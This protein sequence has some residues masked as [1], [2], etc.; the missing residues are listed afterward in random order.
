MAN[1]EESLLDLMAVK[2]PCIQIRTSLEKEVF[3]TLINILSSNNI[4][5]IYRIDELDR[6][7][8][9]SVNTNGII[10]KQEV[11]NEEGDPVVFNPMVLLPWTRELMNSE[12]NIESSAFIFV[13]YDYTFD[14]PTFRRWIKDVFEFSNKKYIPFI[15]ISSNPSI[16]EDLDHLFSVIYYDTPNQ[17][18]IIELLDTYKEVKNVQFDSET[19]ADKF[20]GFNRTE[21]IEC[22]DYSFYKYDEI[23]LSYL[24]TKR[25]EVIKKSNILDYKEP[26]ISME[27]IAGNQEFKR[28]YNEVKLS[29]LPEARQ[30]NIPMPKGYLA[31]GPAGQGKTIGA[32]AIA[33]DLEIP[34]LILNMSSILSKFVGE[35]ER[36]IDTAVKLIKQSAPC[37]LLID[38][39]EKNLGGYASSNASDSGTLARVFGKILNLLA[40][41]DNGIFTVMT[42]NNVKDL[43]PELTRAGRLDGFIYFNYGDATEREAIFKVHLEKRGHANVGET[44]LKQIA[45][46]TNKYSGAEI[47]QVVISAIRKAFVRKVQEGSDTY[48]I[49]INDFMEAKKDVIPISV[50]SKETIEEL[51]KWAKGRALFANKITKESSKASIDIDDIDVSD[52]KPKAIRKPKH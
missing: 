45:K 16:P 47:E 38:E 11:E 31:L 14:R 25:I 49:T 13:D 18:E 39:V 15:F 28:W 6:V 33:K 40:E 17:E 52:L 21:I 24:N 41:N 1:F 19:I 42:S 46:E 29:F 37:V 4:D 32:E 27:D 43:P 7:Q 34:M 51:D 35:S 23:D 26:K 5:N 20:V 10:T 44:V 36:Q 22:L 48:E 9:I 30:Y 50:S 3:P 2:K 12:S 8:K